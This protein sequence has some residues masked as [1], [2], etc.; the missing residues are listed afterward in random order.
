MTPFRQRQMATRLRRQAEEL[1]EDARRLEAA[2]DKA[3]GKGKKKPT[4]S[5]TFSSAKPK[6]SR[7]Y[8]GDLKRRIEEAEKAG[9]TAK[10]NRLKRELK[11]EQRKAGGPRNTQS[12]GG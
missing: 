10:A 3:K 8:F 6:R 2:A 1:V 12:R 9:S 4:R 7:G 5:V 11:E